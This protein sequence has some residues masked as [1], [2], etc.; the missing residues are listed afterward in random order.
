MVNHTEC[1]RIVQQYWHGYEVN[2]YF[3]S[4]LRNA[5]DYCNEKNE[6][7]NNN[8]L[9]EN[10]TFSFRFTSV[11]EIHDILNSIKTDAFGTDNISSTMLKYSSPFIDNIT[12]H[13]INC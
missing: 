3:A 2:R 9:E 12:T 8:V 11:E 5:S 10:N 7:Y 6:F 4:Y 1:L 13:I